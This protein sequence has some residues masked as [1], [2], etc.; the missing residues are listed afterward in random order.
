M[1]FKMFKLKN[2][3]AFLCVFNTCSA[4][5]LNDAEIATTILKIPALILKNNINQQSEYR[6]IAII[7]VDVLRLANEIL[8]IINKND[9]IE[10][11]KYD[12]CWMMHD[13]ASLIMHIRDVA[14]EPEDGLGFDE[15]VNALK[16]ILKTAHT[17]LLPLIEGVTGLLA[18]TSDNTIKIEDAYFRLQ[19]KSFNSMARLLDSIVTSNYK[20]RAQILYGMALL[21]A[22]VIAIKDICEMHS[23][24]RTEEDNRRREQEERE[25]EAKIA[26]DNRRREQAEQEQQAR[27]A[28]ALEAA[29]RNEE[30]ER[31]RRMREA[32][33]NLKRQEEANLRNIALQ[34]AVGNP[35]RVAWEKVARLET[36]TRTLQEAEDRTNNAGH[37]MYRENFRLD[38]DTEWSHSFDPCAAYYENSWWGRMEKER[39]EKEKNRE[40]CSK[41]V[42]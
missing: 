31:E 30:Y 2:I 15:N 23:L 14:Y 20:S 27:E 22:I 41:R 33:E 34:K 32:E 40:T 11:H 9:E 37:D 5:S 21:I 6:H 13:A 25:Q 1:A 10:F 39:V 8:S 19:C 42:T 18:A 26:E 3:C 36:E 7:S 29:R 24:V 17:K 35:L 38:M 16:G 28:R 4:M 12:Y